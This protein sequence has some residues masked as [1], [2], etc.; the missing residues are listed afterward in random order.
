MEIGVIYC[1]EL[2]SCCPLQDQRPNPRWRKGASCAP[3]AGK[4]N[5]RR[6]EGSP[7]GPARARL[8]LG[9]H[10][11]QEDWGEGLACSAAQQEVDAAVA[12]GSGL[13][14]FDLLLTPTRTH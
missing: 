14:D 4:Q 2:T 13:V 1:G 5:C 10:P 7:P 3:K 9:K 12:L 6:P 11:E 8:A